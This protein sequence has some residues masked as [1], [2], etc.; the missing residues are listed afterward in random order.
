MNETDNKITAIACSIFR[1]EIEILQKE[2]KLSIPVV[3]LDSMQHMV[4]EKLHWNMKRAIE[5]QIRQGRKVVL[6]YGE[7]HAFIN[8]HLDDPNIARV[9]GINCV[10][11][12]LGRE[13]Y[14]ILRKEGAFFLM[15]EWA[16]RWKT[17]FQK[18]LGLSDENAKDLMKEMHTKLIYVDTGSVPVPIEIIDQ[19][20]E[21]TGLPVEIKPV[22]LDHFFNIINEA[23][24]RLKF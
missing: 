1:R 13:T 9:S 11:T 4:P 19:I 22:T 14:R 5:E 3:Y 18:E 8:T 21:Y 17:I 24:E 6:I 16:V 15:P 23:I 2:N 12:L 10:E 20:S 7:C